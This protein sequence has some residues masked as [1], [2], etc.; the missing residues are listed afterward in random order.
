M[1]WESN[2]GFSALISNLKFKISK[3]FLMFKFLIFEI[4]PKHQILKILSFQA[5]TRQ[6]R[7]N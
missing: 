7:V 6:S 1:L 2:R 4:N 5:A 3:Q